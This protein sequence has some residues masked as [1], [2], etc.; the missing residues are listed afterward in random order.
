MNGVLRKWTN[1]VLVLSEPPTVQTLLGCK[2]LVSV[3][4]ALFPLP[5]LTARVNGLS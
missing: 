4:K 1:R 3:S 2:V 5:E